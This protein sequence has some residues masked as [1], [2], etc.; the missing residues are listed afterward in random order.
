MKDELIHDY[1]LLFSQ[2]PGD[3][4]GEV[5]GRGKVSQGQRELRVLRAGQA[6]A[7]PGRHNDAARQSFH[8]QAEHQLSQAQ[9]LHGA[10][11]SPLEQGY[12]PDVQGNQR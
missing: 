6:T 8:H 12:A 7:P 2:H 9:G 10:R 3:A 1:Y 5:E 11:R 4:E